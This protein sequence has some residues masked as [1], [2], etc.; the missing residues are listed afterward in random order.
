[1][2]GVI[3]LY[4]IKK[5]GEDPCFLNRDQVIFPGGLFFNKDET[6][7]GL[8]FRKEWY[9]AQISWMIL[10]AFSPHLLHRLDRT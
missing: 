6:R 2:S 7:L 5:K 1:M 4:V 8:V 9:K 3:F 10:H